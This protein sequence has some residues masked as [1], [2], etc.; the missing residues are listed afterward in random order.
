M[1]MHFGFITVVI[2]K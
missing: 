1:L 2:I